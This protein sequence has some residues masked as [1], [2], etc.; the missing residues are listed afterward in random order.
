MDN[1]LTLAG[2]FKTHVELQEYCDAQFVAL[3]RAQKRI[4]TLEAEVTH[5][6][7]L[8]SSTTKLIDEPAIEKIVVSPE[9]AICEIQ[10]K[11]LQ[12]QAL[13]REL[14]LE[15]TKRLDLLVKNLYLA[16]GQATAVIQTERLP[17]QVTEAELVAIAQVE[18]LPSE[19]VSE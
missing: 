18:H 19:S 16:K 11:K 6:K 3:E 5:L 15:E 14:T 12:Q 8:L 7:E 1:I 13:I 4:S 10:I 17:D 9:Q 2:R